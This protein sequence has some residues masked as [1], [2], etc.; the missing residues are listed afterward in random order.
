MK[1]ELPLI[2]QD[3]ADSIEYSA[4]SIVSKIILKSEKMNLTLFAVAEGESMDQ[5]V[6]SREAIVHILEGS[7]EF[8]LK[9]TWHEF[10]AG[11]YFYMPSG[12]LHAIKAKTNFKFLLYL[13]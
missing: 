13:F 1:N 7:G 2:P 5:H 11:S 10:K 6:T 3:I 8:Y 12:L 4:G 9:D